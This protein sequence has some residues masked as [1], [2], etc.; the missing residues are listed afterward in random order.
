MR[1]YIL[2]P[3]I[4]MSV[5]TLSCKT[6]KFEKANEIT[7]LD[8]N[9]NE[10]KIDTTLIEIA[11]LPIHI[12]STKYLIHPI[13]NISQ[14]KRGSG[15]INKSYGKKAFNNLVNAYGDEIR[16]NMNNLL[17]QNINSNNLVPL[18]EENIRI[19]SFRFLRK[20]FKNTKNEVLLFE[21]I[22]SDSNDDKKI[23]LEDK[24]SLYLSNVDGTNFVKIS[25]NNEEIVQTKVINI[26]NK[27]YFKTVEK[28][29]FKKD[30]KKF[31]YY[32]VNLTEKE[33]KPIEYFPLK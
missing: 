27:L 24:V 31:H 28:G 14:I 21:I 33:M 32:Y 26:N 18:T 7:V 8:A 6:E 20:L 2:Y 5:L 22:D 29:K 9:K 4:L 30:K 17:F 3:L 11:D 13:G 1:K 12:D 16:G 25:N 15:Y 10:V 23:N 19:K